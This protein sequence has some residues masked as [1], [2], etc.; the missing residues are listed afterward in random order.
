MYVNV[1]NMQLTIFN[2]KYKAILVSYILLL[3]YTVSAKLLFCYLKDKTENFQIYCHM[4]A[5]LLIVY[6]GVEWSIGAW[7]KVRCIPS[8]PT[9]HLTSL[10]DSAEIRA[11]SA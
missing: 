4:W 5:T 11:F 10:S 9:Y 3:G 6:V 2:I 1:Q 8:F 7:D